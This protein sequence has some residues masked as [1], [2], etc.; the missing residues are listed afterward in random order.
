MTQALIAL[1]AAAAVSAAAWRF[2]A[3]SVTGAVAATL[4]G[5]TVL[6]FAGFGAA[7]V[8]VLFFVSSS[9]LSALPPDGARASRDAR[10]VLANGSVAAL[11]AAFITGYSWAGAAFLGATA[12]AAADT[13]ATEIGVWLG[14]NPRSILTMRPQPPGT[15]GAVSWAGTLAA[16]A[17]SLAVAVAGLWLIPEAAVAWIPIAAAGFLGALADSVLGAAFQ[18]EYRCPA[19]GARPEVA[20]HDGCSRRAA[21]VSGLPGLDNDAV[22][23]LATVI[24]AA[25]A[26]G[27]HGLL[28]AMGSP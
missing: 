19:C 28:D 25:V 12:A 17:G 26:V 3:L 23:W 18:A 22:N 1:A 15:S 5:S 24:G 8:L 13:W 10:Q 20:R 14:R 9:A 2:E 16:L 6:Y 11:A 7:V 21:R 4:V 27:L